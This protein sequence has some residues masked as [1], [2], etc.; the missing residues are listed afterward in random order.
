M[1]DPFFKPSLSRALT[2]CRG[3]SVTLGFRLQVSIEHSCQNDVVL[4]LA[5]LQVMG[6]ECSSQ[7]L[8]KTQL[9]VCFIFNTR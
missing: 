8:I 3:T 4:R 7:N 6:N 5:L 1:F 9:Q 2:P